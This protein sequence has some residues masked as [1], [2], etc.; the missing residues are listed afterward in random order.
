M[1]VR[2][3]TPVLAISALAAAW[4][5]AQVCPASDEDLRVLLDG[6]KVVDAPGLPG[7]VCAFGEDAF[8]VVVGR[9]KRG[10]PLPLV[11]ASRFGK[12][13]AVAFG[14]DGF[15]SPKTLDIGDTGRLV[16]NAARWAAGRSGPVTVGVHQRKGLAP[17]LQKHGLDA[18]DVALDQLDTVDVVIARPNRVGRAG[19]DKLSQFVAKG[20]GL[21]AGEWAGGGS[22]SIQARR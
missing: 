13:R 20:K 22:S 17:A 9:V 1:S 12:G 21:L 14:K 11:V 15:F 10:G 19:I 5:V 7:P 2:E 4:A 6:V 16:A 18:R 3:A 8:A